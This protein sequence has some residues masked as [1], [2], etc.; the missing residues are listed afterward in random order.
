MRSLRVSLLLKVGLQIFRGFYERNQPFAESS[1]F[2]RVLHTFKIDFFKIQ[3]FREEQ[4]EAIPSQMKTRF[5]APRIGS[6]SVALKD[7]DVDHEF[8]LA[9]PL[10]NIDFEFRETSLP[11]SPQKRVPPPHRAERNRLRASAAH[12]PAT[13]P[14]IELK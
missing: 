8:H 4:V 3:E 7:F 14:I 9:Q 13:S 5:H 10:P 11:I 6:S 1:K 2:E 12:K